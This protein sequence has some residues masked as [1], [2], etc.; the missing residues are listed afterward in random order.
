M[1]ASGDHRYLAVPGYLHIVV[2]N[3]FRLHVP[4]GKYSDI[5]I[6]SHYRTVRGRDAKLVGVP[7]FEKADIALDPGC[8]SFVLELNQFLLY[9]VGRLR[10]RGYECHQAPVD[11]RYYMP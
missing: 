7:L 9:L 8:F 2:L 1:F 4:A 6:S 11:E 10:P 3:T 5:R